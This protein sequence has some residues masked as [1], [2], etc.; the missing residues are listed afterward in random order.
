M[1]HL[2]IV[3]MLSL[4]AIE[5]AWGGYRV[6]RFLQL[7][8][9]EQ[10]RILMASY[11]TATT[12]LAFGVG[13]N[14]KPVTEKMVACLKEREFGWLRKTF[15]EYVSKYNLGSTFGANFAHSMAWKC[16]LLRFKD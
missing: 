5:P 8:D 9:G 12:L 15:L 6:E 13:E 4:I 11:E 16:E 7:D 2:I 1:R 14:P 3:A 10:E